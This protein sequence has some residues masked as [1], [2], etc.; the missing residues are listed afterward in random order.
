MPCVPTERRFLCSEIVI[1]RWSPSW[2]PTREAAA[3]LE[4][5][6]PAG[7]EFS[8]EI[9]IPENTSVRIEGRDF[10]WRGIVRWCRME[11]SGFIIEVEFLPQSRWNRRKY[12]PDHFFDPAVLLGY[13]TLLAS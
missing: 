12:L 3:N 5:I 9:A 2:G 6:W 7:A 8:S 10:E 11:E 13:P 4:S 1:L